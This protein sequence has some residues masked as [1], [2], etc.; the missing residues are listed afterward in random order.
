MSR[1]I[2]FRSVL[3]LAGGLL[4]AQA[5]CQSSD[6]DGG[7]PPLPRAG[8]ATDANGGPGPFEE[9]GGEFTTTASGLKYR[10]T[11]EGDGESPQAS[12]RV[13][14][15]YEGKLADGSVFDS[16]YQHGR[17]AE[18]SL[19]GVIPGWTEGMQLVKQGG[20]IELIIPAD[21]GYGERGSPPD[22]PPNA[23]LYFTVELLDIL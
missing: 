2:F 8:S 22:I 20:M 10:I 17:P 1:T 16:S 3:F 12:D 5:G 21:I 9:S 15:H 13:R 23:T 18:F 4:V 11:R 19:G 7:G 14:V 6:N